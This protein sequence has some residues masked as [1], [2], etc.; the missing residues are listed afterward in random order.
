MFEFIRQRGNVALEEM[1]RTFNMGLGIILVV[2]KAK[3]A[4]VQDSLQRHDQQ[5]NLVGEIVKGSGKVVYI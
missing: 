5:F 2:P 3:A 1:Y 4:S